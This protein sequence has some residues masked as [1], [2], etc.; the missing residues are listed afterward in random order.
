[1]SWQ[2]KHLRSGSAGWKPQGLPREVETNPKFPPGRVLAATPVSSTPRL[3]PMET[4]GNREADGD[5]THYIT[6]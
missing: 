4:E 6:P 1:M 2:I 3:L 5:M